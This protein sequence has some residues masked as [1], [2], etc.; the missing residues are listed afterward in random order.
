MCCTGLD[1]RLTLFSHQVNYK[2][3]QLTNEIKKIGKWLLMLDLFNFV[4]LKKPFREKVYI[5]NFFIIL[6]TL[7]NI[8]QQKTA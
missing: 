7:K 4:S 8:F 1:V 3:M 2:Q 6:S 5:E